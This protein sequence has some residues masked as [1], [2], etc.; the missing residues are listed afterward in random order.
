MVVETRV[1]KGMNRVGFVPLN[2]TYSQE[3]IS[4]P[5]SATCGGLATQLNLSNFRS[6]GFNDFRF[7][8][9]AGHEIPRSMF[10]ERTFPT[11]V[12]AWTL[13]RSA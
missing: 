8:N 4:T 9:E 10:I 6:H 2:I 1:T 5:Y 11:F 7:G 12:A 3:H 13:S